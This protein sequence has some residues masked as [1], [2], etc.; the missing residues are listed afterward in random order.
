LV[1]I[2]DVQVNETACVTVLLGDF[3]ARVIEDVTDDHLRALRNH[4]RR[5]DYVPLYILRGLETLHIEFG[6]KS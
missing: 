3:A 1:R 6:A 2:G 5:F 4:A